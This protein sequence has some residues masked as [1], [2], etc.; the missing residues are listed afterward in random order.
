VTKAL[1]EEREVFG[2]EAGWPN[3]AT[4]VEDLGGTPTSNGR[5][6]ST[7]TGSTT[8]GSTTRSA[9]SVS[10]EFEDVFYDETEPANQAG[11]ETT[12]SLSNPA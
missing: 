4:D 3:A 5:R 7:S 9:T 10:A 11:S 8:A 1:A 2:L 6:S 12:E